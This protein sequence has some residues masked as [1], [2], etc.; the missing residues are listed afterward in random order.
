MRMQ[1]DEAATA[2]PEAA[3]AAAQ[4]ERFPTLRSD[5]LLSAF[6]G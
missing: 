6:A 3:Q 5:H 4:K 1:A 2:L